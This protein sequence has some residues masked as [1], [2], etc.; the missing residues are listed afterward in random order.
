MS[1]SSS[2]ARTVVGDQDGQRSTIEN[3][4]G[5][6]AFRE[7][8]HQE[9]PL[10]ENGS[11]PHRRQVDGLETMALQKGRSG[12]RGERHVGNDAEVAV[13]SAA[14][15]PEQLVLA[16]GLVDVT[17]T[18]DQG[19]FLQ[20]VASQAIGPRKQPVASA[21]RE[22]ADTNAGT[23]P[24]WQK[25]S[26]RDQRV[27]DLGEK[28]AGLDADTGG[29]EPLDPVQLRHIDDQA[30]VEGGKAFKRVASTFD[31]H[32]ELVLAGM[33]DGLGNVCRAATHGD[34]R[35]LPGDGFIETS[36]KAGV[37]RT[38]AGDEFQGDRGR[39]GRESGYLG[40]GGTAQG[41][42]GQSHN[43]QSEKPFAGNGIRRCDGPGA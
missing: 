30:I 29:I 32:L 36:C 35:R 28:A 25:S 34:G 20:M 31:R 11:G 1:A 12:T 8:S 4:S 26:A 9:K 23:R 18:I 10:L 43:G 40:S 19:E 37:F 21:Q 24:G 17:P 39:W 6:T 27:I 3:E 14:A 15:S 38:L 41:K 5:E 13:A 22:A 2:G 42:T 33:G 16:A 7:L